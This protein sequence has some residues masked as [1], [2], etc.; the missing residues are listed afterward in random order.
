[1]KGAF[2]EDLG[3]YNP[4]TD[5]FEIRSERVLHWLSVG[6]QPTDTVEQIFK[7]AG[8][9]RKLSEVKGSA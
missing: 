1:L 7:K 3:W 9:I 4:H 2:I 6:A 8:I 5:K